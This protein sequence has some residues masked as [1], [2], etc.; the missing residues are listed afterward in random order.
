MSGRAHVSGAADWHVVASHLGLILARR[1]LANSGVRCMQSRG[2]PPCGSKCRC[3]ASML[4]PRGKSSQ[5][6][7]VV[8]AVPVSDS[9]KV[10]PAST[11]VSNTN[12]V[13]LSL[14]RTS[15]GWSI[16]S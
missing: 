3:P 12:F 16:E 2:S 15:D 4:L 5:R 7:A 8:S 1:L 10:V 11:C 13:R 6:P 14:C 9:G